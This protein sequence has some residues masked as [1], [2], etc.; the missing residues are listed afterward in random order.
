MHLKQQQTQLRQP[1]F[2][3]LQDLITS[4]DRELSAQKAIIDSLRQ[5]LRNRNFQNGSGFVEQ[6]DELQGRLRES[7]QKNHLLNM[8]L[9]H[10]YKI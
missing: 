2:A 9:K 5:D 7:E 10:M 3:A 6:L 8:E 1:D 4:K